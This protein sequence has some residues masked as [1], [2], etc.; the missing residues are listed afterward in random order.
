VGTFVLLIMDNLGHMGVPSA[1]IEDVAVDPEWHGRGVGK[2]MLD[3]ALTVA[4]KEGCYKAVLSSNL[5]RE[6]A[7]PSMRH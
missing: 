6:R 2:M 1:V 4:S 5:K 7:T 3:Y